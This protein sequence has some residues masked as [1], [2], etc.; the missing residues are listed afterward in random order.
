M[1][2]EPDL[3]P[4]NALQP[5]PAPPPQRGRGLIARLFAA[6]L[7]IIITTSLTIA[8][9]GAAYIGLGFS[10]GTPRQIDEISARMG[11]VEAREALLLAENNAMRTQVAESSR[12]SD[13]QGETLD[14][15]QR[16]V[17]DLSMLRDELRQQL[18]ASRNEN[19]TVVAEIRTSR[20]AVALFATAEAGRAALLDDLKRRS[21]RIERFFLRLSDISEDA[22]LDLGVKS[23]PEAPT[24]TLTPA[25]TP[26]ANLTS[27]PTLTPTATSTPTPTEATPTAT[28]TRTPTATPRRPTATP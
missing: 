4:T 10:P 11:T 8:A 2:D 20:D 24:P 18:A 3:T 19:A 5:L 16:Q 6:L 7:V 12:R 15:L 14:E 21:D 17:S 26:T 28:N 23:P 1:S 27:T 13:D 9:V 25:V 22:A